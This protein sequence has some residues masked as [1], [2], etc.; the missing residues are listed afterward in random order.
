[1]E[2]YERPELVC[3]EEM[4]E[5]ADAYSASAAGVII[6]AIVVVVLLPPKKVY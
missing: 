1:M 2:G 6:V 4:V 3:D 5:C